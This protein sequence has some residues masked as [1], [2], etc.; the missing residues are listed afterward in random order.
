VV[1]VQS[2]WFPNI[3]CDPQTF[4]P[5]IFAA[6]AADFQAATH[7]IHRSSRHPSQI[8]IPRVVTHLT[9]GGTGAGVGVG[10][11]G[12]SVGRNRQ[13]PFNRPMTRG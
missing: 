11:S 6:R 10:R 12:G 4:V 3:D 13:C 8:N 1:Q 2:T 7:R 5:S 9:T